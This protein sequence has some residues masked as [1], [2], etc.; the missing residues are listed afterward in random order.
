LHANKVQ[1]IVA[2]DGRRV[3]STGYRGRRLFSGQILQTESGGFP[4]RGFAVKA[5]RFSFGA[6]GAVKRYAK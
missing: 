4:C 2:F 1:I 5:S 6:V 3:L